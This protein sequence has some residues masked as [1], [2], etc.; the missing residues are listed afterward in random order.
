MSPP[1]GSHQ[2][3]PLPPP[4][5]RPAPPP[6]TSPP[7]TEAPQPLNQPATRR[8][9]PCEPHPAQ[10]G[11]GRGLGRAGRSPLSGGRSDVGDEDQGV[12][13]PDHVRPGATLGATRTNGL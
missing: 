6:E 13:G 5:E 3:R 12:T 9:E 10:G 11:P 8:T 7:T 2:P 4:L 1:P